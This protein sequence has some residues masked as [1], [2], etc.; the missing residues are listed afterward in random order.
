MAIRLTEFPEPKT[1]TPAAEE[2]MQ[3]GRAHV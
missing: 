2:T 1:P 3:I